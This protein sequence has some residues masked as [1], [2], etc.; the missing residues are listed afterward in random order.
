MSWGSILVVL[1]QILAADPPSGMVDP[2]SLVPDLMVDLRY[3]TKDNFLK[4][5]L[6]GDM[7][8]CFL[9]EDA[10]RM[11]VEA[12][13]LLKRFRPELRLL[14]WDC[15]RPASVQKKMWQ[16]VKGTPKEP[17]VA[18]PDRGGSVHQTGCAVD[19]TLAGPD[20]KPLDLGSGFDEF[21][22]SAQPRRELQL[23]REGKLTLEQV[24]NRLLLRW[25]M[26]A[27]GFYPTQIEWWHFECAPSEAALQRY[28]KVP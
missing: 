24:S 15:L 17:F 2:T 21:G 5:D 9:H 25:A 16:R 13:R 20:G 18:N 6:Y 3:S 23:L 10:A 19:L 27:A 14:L 12:D 22:P 4:E 1:I 26:S 7:Q 28:P 11:L 8:R